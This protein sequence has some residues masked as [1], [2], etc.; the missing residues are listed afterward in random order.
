MENGEES[1]GCGELA[2]VGPLAA[3]FGE[4]VWPDLEH[5]ERAALQASHPTNKADI[6]P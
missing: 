1:G 3:V 5:V 4:A 6:I 2:D